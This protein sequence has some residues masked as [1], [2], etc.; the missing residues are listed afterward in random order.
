M[1]IALGLFVVGM[2]LSALFSGSETGF[3]RVSRVRLLID[4]LSG[5]RTAKWLLWASNNPA[6]FVATA[7]VGN[8][9]AN[10]LT[11]R[12]IVTR[13]LVSSSHNT[14]LASA[15]PSM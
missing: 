12:A 5:D 8:N 9:V 11:S 13:V 15:S 1:T 14:F 3:Y 2:L 6:A 7:L 4:A 10:Y